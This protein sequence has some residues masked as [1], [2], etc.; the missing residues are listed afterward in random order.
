LAFVFV[1]G[2]VLS[3]E[4]TEDRDTAH[5]VAAFQGGDRDAFG[6][7]YMRHFGRIYAYLLRALGDAVEAEDLTQQVFTAALRELPRVLS[8]PFRAWLFSVAH[9]AAIDHRRR[10]HRVDVRAPD[11]LHEL[12]RG[13]AETG[14]VDAI[15][16]IS[17]GALLALLD[18]LTDYQ[19]QVLELR[20]HFDHPWAIVARTLGRSE[21]AVRQAD[22]EA[23]RFLRERLPGGVGRPAPDA[24]GLPMRRLAWPA[25]ALS[26]SFSVIRGRI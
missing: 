24:D 22:R 19:R 7:L 17:D 2:P 1:V 3:G 4:H 13:L 9:N 5:L 25:R 12:R 8:E 14:E 16:W 26:T 15:G 18:E 11:E 20:Y 23:R 21:D 6:V 10:H